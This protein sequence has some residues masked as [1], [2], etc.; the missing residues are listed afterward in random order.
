MY[1][2]AECTGTAINRYAI[3]LGQCYGGILYQKVGASQAPG[4][5]APVAESVGSS[6]SSSD[7]GCFAGSETVRLES[8]E[9]RQISLIT[10]G[11]RV[12][13]ADAAGKTSFSE[14]V[15]VPHSANIDTAIFVH[16]TTTSGRDI[17]MTKNHVLPAGACGSSSPL[18]LKHA[19][20]VTVNDCV[21]TIEGE[22]RVSMVPTI[23]AEGLYTIV[24][25]EEFVVVNGI[26]ASPFAYNHVAGNLYYHLHRFLYD[27]APQL[28]LSSLVRSFNEV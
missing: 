8:G 26:I 3:A 5:S 28:L 9:D 15:F 24:T 13:A 1:S 4:S 18:P 16:I 21:M 17:K 23:L 22:E 11:D 10:A 7:K 2:G 19:S 12:Q 6:S 14:V 20:L 27:T 25:K